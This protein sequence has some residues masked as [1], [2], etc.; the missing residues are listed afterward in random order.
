MYRN[1]FNLDP[2]GFWRG[3]DAPDRQGITEIRYVEG[4]Y[5]IWDELLRRG[6]PGCAIDNCASGGRRI[7]LETCHALACRSGGATP[8][9]AAA[10]PIGTR[11]KPPA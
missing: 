1:D 7:D 3:A 8:V 10:T 2:L 6:I 5:A 9:A 11:P 4:Q